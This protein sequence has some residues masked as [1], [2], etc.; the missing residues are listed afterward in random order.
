MKVEEY[1]VVYATLK[2]IRIYK[3]EKPEEFRLLFPDGVPSDE[4]AAQSALLDRLVKGL[5]ALEF[6][7]PLK[8]GKPDYASVD[9]GRI[10]T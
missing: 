3:R 9:E 5:P 7:P 10:V 4:A 1:R 8:D 2:W 6:P